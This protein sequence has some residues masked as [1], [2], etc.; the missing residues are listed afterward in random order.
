M[1]P[2]QA[3]DAVVVGGGVAG[4]AAAALLARSQARV[5]VLTPE[6]GAAPPAGPFELRNYAIT[7]ASRRVLQAAGAWDMLAGERLGAFDAIEVWDAGSSGAVSFA[8][9]AAHE[10]PMGWIVEH[11][12][13]VTA[14][15]GAARGAGVTIMEQ[16]LAGLEI[17]QPS[18]LRLAD[19][20]TLSAR[21]VIGAD[22]RESFVRQAVGLGFERTP[23]DH[24]A[25]VA[26]VVTSVPHGRIAR[27]RFLA[28]GPLAFLPLPD[29]RACSI[30]WSCTP[31]LAAE[32]EAAD[33]A[34]FMQR[35]AEAFDRRLGDIRD[36]SP[37][38]AFAL[39]RAQA[40][41]WTH[42][43]CV[44]LG[45]AAHVV[46]PLAGQ[47]LNLGLMDVAALVECVGAPGSERQWPAPA[48]LR[49]YERWRK[50]EAQELL[51]MTDALKRVFAHDALPWRGLRG[52]G[53]RLTD[54]VAPI[55][56]WLAARAMGERGDLPRLA[57]GRP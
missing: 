11:R 28:S 54:S 8:P 39:E 42:G 40:T 7:P 43:N 30:V 53:M 24:R 22:G 44:L 1:S 48:A 19:G 13:L 57:R 52:L 21:L 41:E 17:G 29:A 9:P 27:Q 32:I 23:Y 15:A 37:R 56:T 5:C 14:L 31:E 46:H 12:N 33:D 45:D 10:G 55:K 6:L 25:I 26:N 4:L 2:T 16:S 3:F 18:T 38:L 51:A 35:L 36:T 50:S 47:G 20:G 49:R 34:A